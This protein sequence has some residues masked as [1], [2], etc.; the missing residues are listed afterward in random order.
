MLETAAAVVA[1]AA[2]HTSGA[3]AF[4]GEQMLPAVPQWHDWHDLGSGDEDDACCQAH[5]TA[6]TSDAAGEDGLG[7]PDQELSGW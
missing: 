5:A 2:A 3:F 7:T 6:V 1:V 4:D